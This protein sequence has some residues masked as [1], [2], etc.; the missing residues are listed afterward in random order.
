MLLTEFSQYLF[1]AKC[2]SS[3]F[4]LW[5]N[6]NRDAVGGTVSC[7]FPSFYIYFA[8]IVITLGTVLTW[9]QER[10][11][12][13]KKYC[14]SILRQF[15][16]RSLEGHQINKYGNWQVILRQIELL[17]TGA[18][19]GG[20]VGEYAN[21]QIVLGWSFPATCPWVKM[22][23]CVGRPVYFFSLN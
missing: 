16:S 19:P 7:V 1:V 4:C 13:C 3:Q 18:F 15:P 12:V 11:P 5:K 10:H 17:G 6:R 23:A 9:H 21:S 20:S 2:W 22:F 14:C 8:F